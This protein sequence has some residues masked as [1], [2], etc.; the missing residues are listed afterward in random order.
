MRISV[1]RLVIG[2]CL[3]ATGA[4][5][6]LANLGRVD[7]LGALHTWWPLSLVIWGLLELVNTLVI[8]PARKR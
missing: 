2:F 5:W 6:T 7:L 3:V 4:L 8:G 1:E